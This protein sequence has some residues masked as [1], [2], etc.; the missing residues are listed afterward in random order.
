MSSSPHQSNYLSQLHKCFADTTK[1]LLDISHPLNCEV[2]KLVLDLLVDY[3]VHFKQAIAVGTGGD[4]L[5][6]NHEFEMDDELVCESEVDANKELDIDAE[7]QSIARSLQEMSL[8]LLM[9]ADERL[10]EFLEES[11]LRLEA[12]IDFG[13]MEGVPL[14]LSEVEQL[15]Y[16]IQ[17]TLDALIRPHRDEAAAEDD[18]VFMLMNPLDVQ[19]PLPYTE[20]FMGVLD[21]VTDSL[22]PKFRSLMLPLIDRDTVSEAHKTALIAHQKD[23]DKAEQL[24]SDCKKWNEAAKEV[25]MAIDNLQRISDTIGTW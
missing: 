19:V 6:M 10:K 20:A 1:A 21:E 3:G 11:I 23:L 18:P 5:E 14:L 16:S 8:E 2:R 24:I 25:E 9:T 12:H 4:E 17:D 22:L 15:I 13:S 7:L